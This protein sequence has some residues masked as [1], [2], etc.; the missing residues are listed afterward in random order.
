MLLRLNRDYASLS[1][2]HPKD[3][4][5]RLFDRNATM[6]LRDIGGRTGSLKVDNRG[7]LILRGK[8][9]TTSIDT[10]ADFEVVDLRHS[11]SRGDQ[12]RWSAAFLNLLVD[13]VSGVASSFSIDRDA[14]NLMDPGYTEPTDATLLPNGD[15]VAVTIVRSQH[16][17]IVNFVTGE[18]RLLNLAGSY[19]NSD[20]VVEEDALWV[21]NYDTF[22]RIDLETLQVRASPKLQAQYRDPQ[23]GLM[24]SA[25]VGVPRISPSLNGWLIPRPYSGDVLLVSKDALRPERRLPCG[26]H[27]YAIVEFDEGD[28][29]I[30]NHP[31]DSFQTATIGQFVDL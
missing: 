5:L 10:T 9:E 21:V 19:G 29:L 31:F 16:M 13:S 30:L 17:A 28:L 26:G 4:G 8:S 6:T 24:T 2:V 23:Y 11:Q 14:L 20:A 18:T 25:F 1:W 3:G 27:P 22:C 12:A 15:E 7:Q